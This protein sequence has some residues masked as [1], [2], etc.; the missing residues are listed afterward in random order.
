MNDDTAISLIN[1]SKVF[2]RYPHP[3]DRLK[4]LLLP[5]KQ[6]AE[7]FWALRD[8]TLSI[9]RGETIGI[10]GRNDSGKSI[11][12]QT[13]VGALPHRLS[14]TAGRSAAFVFTTT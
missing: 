7:E 2:K 10:V 13:I 1:V 11:L 6:H 4:E 12:L 14:E 3:A 8:I 9:P 5:G